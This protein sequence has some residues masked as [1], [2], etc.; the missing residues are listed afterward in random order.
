MQVSHVLQTGTVSF[1]DER[2]VANAG[3]GLVALLMQRLE[4][5]S[6]ADAALTKGFRPGRKVASVVA[7]MALGADCIDD[8]RV[9]RCGSTERVL[10]FKAMSPEIVGQWLR[11]LSWG[12]VRQ[13]DRLLEQVTQRAWALGAGPGAERLTLDFDSSVCEVYGSKKQ[14]ASWAYTG[15]FGYHPLLCTRADTGEMLGA[16]MREGAANAARGAEDF[17]AENVRR[18][19]RCGATGEIVV[20]AD[21][22][23]YIHDVIARCRKLKVRYS[24]SVRMTPLIVE[25]IRG[26]QRWTPIRIKGQYAEVG[27]IAMPGDH[28]RRMIVRRV[29]PAAPDAAAPRLFDEWLHAGFIT[30]QLDGDAVELDREHRRRAVQELAIGDLKDGP[31]AHLPSGNFNANAA[32]LTLACL[33]HN[34][35]RWV[36]RLGLDQRGLMVARTMRFRLLQI[37]ARITRSARRTTIHMP[38]RWPWDREFLTALRRI[39]GLTPKPC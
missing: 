3:V 36:H 11:S 31:L 25:S 38:A 37:P 18:A 12:N 13:L 39:R 29:K 10:G 19:R 22:A 32:W 27:E 26:I 35:L 7:G 9:L 1:D 2:V 5:V 28:G 23:F 16:R 21:S 6:A 24:I 33:A 14:G 20:R 17:I 8:L 30:D 34:M 4:L 15:A